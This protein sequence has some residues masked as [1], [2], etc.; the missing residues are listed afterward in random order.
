MTDAPHSLPLIS[1]F[2]MIVTFLAIANGFIFKDSLEYQVD[3]WNRCRE[4]QARIEYRRPHLIVAYLSLNFFLFCFVAA[5]LSVFKIGY[6]VA[7]ALGAVVVFPLALLIWVQLGSMLTLLVQG[8]S[9]AI[10][11]DYVGAAPEQSKET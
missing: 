11:I 9:Q 5:C 1:T 3:R 2:I 4:T 7:I 8:G 10:D 6:E